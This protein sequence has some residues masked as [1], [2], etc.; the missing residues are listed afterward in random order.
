[1][2][3]VRKAETATK[4]DFIRAS[5]AMRLLVL[6]ADAAQIYAGR[7][8]TDTEMKPIDSL[9]DKAYKA[10]QHFDE[11]VKAEQTEVVVKDCRALAN[12]MGDQ[13]QEMVGR[14]YVGIEPMA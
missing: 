11:K 2:K 1:M 9:V 12:F 8:L 14:F 7:I 4:W 10:Q 13:V 6:T 5:V 3:R